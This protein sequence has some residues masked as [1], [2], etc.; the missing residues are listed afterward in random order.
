[1]K[2]DPCVGDLAICCVFPDSFTVT[3]GV[4]STPKRRVK[5]GPSP[6]A[7]SRR[8]WASPSKGNLTCRERDAR[9]FYAQEQPV[10]CRV[11]EF[12]QR[13]KHHRHLFGPNNPGQPHSAELMGA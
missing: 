12:D 4:F 9:V 6:S 11:S 8:G 13:R 10:V 7:R 1:M 2:S 5:R 3:R